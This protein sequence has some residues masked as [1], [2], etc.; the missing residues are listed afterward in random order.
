MMCGFRRG[1]VGPKPYDDPRREKGW[2]RVRCGSPPSARHR[3][4]RL[5]VH[6]AE[7]ARQARETGGGRGRWQGFARNPHTELKTALYL[8]F[9]RSVRIV[10]PA[11]TGCGHAT[12]PLV[13]QSTGSCTGQTSR[14][15]PRKC[16]ALRVRIQPSL[17]HSPLRAS[18]PCRPRPGGRRRCVR[19]LHESLPWSLSG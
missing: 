13:H 19:I 12:E 11:K 18:G 7:A 14:K 3:S 15:T 5:S 10:M 1:A 9:C 4:S 2:R 17:V 8:G 6:G 16:W